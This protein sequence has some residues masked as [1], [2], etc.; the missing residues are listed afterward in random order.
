[1]MVAKMFIVLAGLLP[2][3]AFA[4]SV[5]TKKKASRV[6]GENVTGYEV[7]LGAREDEVR[8]SLTKFLKAIGRTRQSGDYITISEPVVGGK[9]YTQTLYA[10]TRSSG[11]SASA[12]IGMQSNVGEESGLDRD[13]DKLAYDFGVTFHREKIQT[14]I[15]ESLRALQAVEKQQSRLVNQNEDLNHKIE[16]NKREKTALEKSLVDNK[17]E[18]DD[19]K[20]KLADNG[21]AQDSIAVTAEQIRKVVEMHKERQRKV[22]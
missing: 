20:R 18:L 5:V 22:R 2:F 14:Q 17:I 10:I 15:D 21:K 1:M 19:L 11:N 12:W 4:Q 3:G 7:S 9:K 16:N 13:L 8:V 6:E